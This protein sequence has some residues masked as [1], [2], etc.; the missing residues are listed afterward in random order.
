VGWTM[1]DETYMRLTF[2]QLRPAWLLL[3]PL[4]P[5]LLYLI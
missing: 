2:I 4:A 5:L 1:N 3:V